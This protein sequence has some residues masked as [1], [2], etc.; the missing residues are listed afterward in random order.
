MAEIERL[1]LWQG[2]VE[3]E[4]EVS[5]S[6]APLVWLHGPWGLRPD[7]PFLELLSRR[8]KVYAP[9]HPGTSAGD[10]DAAH[11]LDGFFDL[12]VYYGEL[13]D[14]LKLDA[15][16]LAGHSFGGAVAAEIAATLARGVKKLVLIDPVGLWRDERPV[17]NWMIMPEDV[18]ARALF[19]DPKGA[20]AQRFFG[21]PDDPKDRLQA[22]ID[23]I[24]AQAC[25]GKFV[26][27][28]PDKGLS[29]RI[30][31]I[32]AP[33]LVLWGEADGVIADAYADD[34]ARPN[35]GARAERI[36]RAGHLPH[37]EAPDAVARL[38]DQFMEA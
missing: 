9:K 16:A 25:T 10:P 7:R 6:G 21:V 5:G 26:W 28:V 2:K 20:A 33:T 23:F 27:P 32:A 15:P 8:H 31:R 1:K 29:K 13:F 18:R 38:I 19:A 17:Q 22:Q 30:H 14:R 12:V 34:F 35:T 24:W 37:L 3:T 11:R 36:E 4:I